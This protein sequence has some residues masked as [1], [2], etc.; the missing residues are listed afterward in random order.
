LD[1]L[2]NPE[3]F[4][5]PGDRILLK[6]NLL[7]AKSP[8]R[9]VTTHPEII[10]AVG[11]MVLD[12]RGKVIIGDSPAGMAKNIR[13]FWEKTGI[14]AAASRL[15]AELVCFEDE[16]IRSFK[17]PDGYVSIADIALEADA[18]I[19]LP[20]LKTHMLTRM[21]GAVKNMFGVVPGFRKSYLHSLAPE[22]LPF[23]RF[24]IAVYRQVIPA[25]NIMDAVIAMEG[26][27]PSSGKPTRI[28][29]IL[30]SQDALA[31]DQV[32]ARLIGENVRDLP[33][34]QAAAEAGLWNPDENSLIL[35][36]DDLTELIP[37][38]FKP[39]DAS[40]LERIPS[41]IKNNLKRI[42]WIRPRADRNLC[43]SCGL[44]IE[45]C[46]QQAMHFVKDVPKI[47]YNRC[48]KCSCCDEICPENA[49]YQQM[50][51]LAKLIS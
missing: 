2:D 7:S 45:N 16:G 38:D 11:E 33:M 1:S 50:S 21:T 6:P 13:H 40:R 48:I 30:V 44:C 14:A 4:I 15:N 9:A 3:Q 47:D 23:C 34:F 10:T 43:S 36:G 41:F 19:N 28:G 39:P 29:A 25:L 26:N 46:P 22:P 5:R 42:F 20:K 18:V 37:Q 35:L 8:D 27:G 32:A 49:I 51:L 31:L 17:A 24:V 12:C